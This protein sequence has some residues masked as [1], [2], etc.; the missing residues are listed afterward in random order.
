[1]NEIIL[2]KSLQ[3]K[4][5]PCEEIT[6]ALPQET[7]KT[8]LNELSEWKQNNQKI[9][10]SFCFKDFVHLMSFVNKMAD[11]AETQNHHPDFFVSY[12]LLHISLSTHKIKGLSENDFI[13]ATKIDEL[14]NHTIQKV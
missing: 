13:L 10:K 4:C 11:L 6:Q 1:M 7:I 12:N 9:E 3:K 5:I 14:F 8:L 2:K